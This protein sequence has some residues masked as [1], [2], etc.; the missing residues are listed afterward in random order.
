M[1][2]YDMIWYCANNLDTNKERYDIKQNI[3]FKI[4]KKFRE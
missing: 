3:V 1:I 4:K 2:W